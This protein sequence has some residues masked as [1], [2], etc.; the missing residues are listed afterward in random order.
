MAAPGIPS[1]LSLLFSPSGQGNI[2]ALLGLN[3]TLV[4]GHLGR[5]VNGLR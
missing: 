5:A 2:V 1:A 4:I 3:V